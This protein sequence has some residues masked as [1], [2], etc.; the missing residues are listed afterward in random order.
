MPLRFTMPQVP[1]PPP[2]LHQD[3]PAAQERS[4]AFPGFNAFP[5][6]GSVLPG[7][8]HPYFAVLVSGTGPMDRDWSS[9]QLPKGRPGRDFALWLQSQ[10]IGSL[11]YDKRYIG[12]RDPR[13]DVSLDAQAGDVAAA[14]LVA[15]ALPE[16][17]G[18]RILLVGQ[19]EGALVALVAARKADAA[20]FL[21]MPGQAMAVLLANQVRAQ[22]PA[23]RQRDHLA[24]LDSVLQAIRWDRPLPAASAAISPGLVRLA[25][26]L[27][28]AETLPFVKATLD[29][30]PWAM[31]SR[32]ATPVAC[33][34]GDR[35]IQSPRP[36][37]VP[38]TFHG[39]ILD[40]PEAN[41][42]LR[43]ETRPAPGLDLQSARSA[44]G[45]GAPLADLA[46]LA[47]WLQRLK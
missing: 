19:G 28:A 34:W 30:D 2:A 24:Y 47:R 15:R 3:A 7:G 31:A 27:M 10:G 21:G 12:S 4:L 46:P 43:R 44:Y 22:L 41:H 18:R 42:F 1:P 45:D 36:V 29:L 39:T 6:K 17:R 14:L 11:R 20:L 5:L 40:L 37:Q 32:L 38:A 33:A 8:T 35:D 16:A 9:P 13:L 26:N 25:R 23:D